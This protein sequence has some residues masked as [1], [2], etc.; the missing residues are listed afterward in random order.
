MAFVKCLKIVQEKLANKIRLCERYKLKNIHSIF[1][2]LLLR[3]VH[4]WEIGSIHWVS[5]QWFALCFRV[6]N[7]WTYAIGALRMPGT[8]FWPIHGK[9]HSQTF[10]FPLPNIS[11]VS[12]RFPPIHPLP[13]SDCFSWSIWSCSREWVIGP[14]IDFHDVTNWNMTKIRKSHRHFSTC[15]IS[16]DLVLLD[17]LVSKVKLSSMLVKCMLVIWE[18]GWF[19]QK[20]QSIFTEIIPLTRMDD[21]L[22]SKIRTRDV[23]KPSSHGMTKY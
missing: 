15:G 12:S 8:H 6:F 5:E 9:Y 14:I 13:I 1:L 23:K 18:N 16:T 4:I 11:L 7:H 2:C 3:L 19:F 21:F 22:L 17:V 10:S 20:M